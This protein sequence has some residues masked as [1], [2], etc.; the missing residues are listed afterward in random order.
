VAAGIG[1]LSLRV[2]AIFFSMITLA[3]A[4]F[5]QIL[6]TQMRDLT[7]GED[8]LSFKTPEALSPSFEPLA[9]LVGPVMG[10][11]VDGK[12]LCYYLLFGAAVVLFLL[13]LI[14]GIRKLI[15]GVTIRREYLGIDV[16]V[17][18]LIRVAAR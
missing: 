7:G 3:A 16:R 8:G 11:T 5:V 18:G 9:G 1:L 10:R 15:S 17:H 2:R 14:S 4:S 12:L 6:A 13:L